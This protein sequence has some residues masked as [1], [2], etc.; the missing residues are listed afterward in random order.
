MKLY[1]NGT[2]KEKVKTECTINRRE[3][4]QLLKKKKPA[5][6]TSSRSLESFKRI[7][8]KKIDIFMNHLKMK[9]SALEEQNKTIEQDKKEEKEQIT[10]GLLRK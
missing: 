7:Y 10:M 6:F 2:D 5:D 8:P 4:H 1:K 9:V 3:L